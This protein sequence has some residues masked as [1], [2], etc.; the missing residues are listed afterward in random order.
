VNEFEMALCH[1]SECWLD[2]CQ[3]CS[4]EEQHFHHWCDKP[5]EASM[6][7]AIL[8]KQREDLAQ[9]LEPCEQQQESVE[10]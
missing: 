2:H 1:L 8:A 3:H 6:D 5:K 7:L 10:S 4:T 9:N